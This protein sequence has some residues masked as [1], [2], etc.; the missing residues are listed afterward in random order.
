MIE[1][2]GAIA[3]EK[4]LDSYE[5]MPKLLRAFTDSKALIDPQ[6]HLIPGTKETYLKQIKKER[7]DLTNAVVDLMKEIPLDSQRTDIGHRY[8]AGRTS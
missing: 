7:K 6:Q 5:T 2:A 3:E 4:N 8:H 1:F